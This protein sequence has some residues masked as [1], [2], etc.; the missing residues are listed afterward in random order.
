MRRRRNFGYRC[1]FGISPVPGG[2]DFRCVIRF[3]F[4]ETDQGKTS[5]VHIIT[6]LCAEFEAGT[7]SS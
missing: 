7:I 1:C 3:T 5:D 6:V 4:A 2:V